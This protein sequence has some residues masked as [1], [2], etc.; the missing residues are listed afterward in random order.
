[1]TIYYVLIENSELEAR[2][3]AINKTKNV[4]LKGA[5]RHSKQE[6]NNKISKVVCWKVVSAEEK[7]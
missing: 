1:M 4:Y 3:K 2:D 5:F 6:K 7:I